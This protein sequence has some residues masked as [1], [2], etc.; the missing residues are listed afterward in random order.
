MDRHPSNPGSDVIALAVSA[1]FTAEPLEPV[2]SFW[3]RELGILAQIRFAPYGQVMQQLLDPSS[4]VSRNRGGI[5]ILLIR[6]EDW[7]NKDGE[8][9]SPAD[10]MQR[11]AHAA[12]RHFARAVG[13]GAVNSPAGFLI[14]FC[15]PSTDGA[16][17]PDTPSV[18]ASMETIV[19][20]ELR[21]TTGVHIVGFEEINRCYPVSDYYDRSADEMG[22]I[23]YTP[24]FFAALGTTICRKVRALRSRPFKVIAVD[25]DQTLWRGVCGEDG[26]EGVRIDPARRFLQQFLLEQQRSGMLLCLCSKNSE[27]EHRRGLP[28][29]Q[30]HDAQAGRLRRRSDQLGA[31]VRKPP[32]ARR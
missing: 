12:A 15:P 10:E 13:K 25:C 28:E 31:E 20:H 30:P 16:S 17:N 29:K 1:T 24:A 27:E 22:H 26:P 19:S 5:N 4:L 18:L 14:V 11:E 6:L 9:S 8:I 23:P 3:M 21:G 2:L 32:V 7:V